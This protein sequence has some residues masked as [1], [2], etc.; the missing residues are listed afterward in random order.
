[1]THD[2]KRNGT[3]TLFPALNVLDGTV[4]GRCM[5]RHWHEEFIR[6]VNVTE[7]AV[8]KGKAIHRY[9][10]QLRHSQASEG[11]GVAGVPP[12]LDIPLHP[13]LGVLAERR[14]RPLRH[15]APAAR[16]VPL[17][18]RPQGCHQAVPCGDQGRPETL[19]VDK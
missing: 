17:G 14:R 6:F 18:C 1:M 8:W 13:D 3:T 5:Q 9:R 7:A 11:Q 12:T 10:R 4:V 16:R 15:T 2:C 19:S